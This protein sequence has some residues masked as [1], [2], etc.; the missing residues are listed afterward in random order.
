MLRIKSQK[1]KT[2]PFLE[3]VNIRL[4]SREDAIFNFLRAAVSDMSANPVI[5]IGGGWVRDKILGLESHDI[6]VTVDTMT[7]KDFVNALEDSA[8]KRYGDKF[9][10]L[11]RLLNVNFETSD[12]QVKNIAAGQISINA[13][14]NTGKDDWQPIDVV[15][16]RKEIWTD[17]N[18]G[19]K[20]L[21]NP[22]VI[23]GTVEEDAF[24]RDLTMNCLFYRI[25]DGQIEDFTGGYPD[26]LSMTLR[27][28]AIPE[29][30]KDGKPPGMDDDAWQYHESL[31]IFTEDPVR[32]LRILR[33]YSKYPKSKIY[34][35]D[36]E[37]G[38]PVINAMR[39]PTVQKLL[40]NKLRD[41]KA[42]GI[43]V[44]KNAEEFRKT[45][46]GARPA[47]ALSIMNE[48]GLL[49]NLLNLPGDFSPLNMDQR[50]KWHE[51]TVINH[52]LAVV[53][54]ANDISQVFGLSPE[55]RRMMNM[56]ALFHD[57][58]KLDPRAQKQKP[59]GYLGF[60]GNPN[61]PE[62]M[63]HEESSQK[64][65][66][67]FV[68]MLKLTNL[69]YQTVG[70]IIY[71]HMEPHDHVDDKVQRSVLGKFKD[72]NP[73]WRMIYIHAMS[74]SASKSSTPDYS[75]IPPYEEVL[76]TIEGIKLPP[77]FSGDDII[78]MTG[79]KPGPII[80]QLI[81]AIRE[82][83]YKNLDLPQPL[84]PEE[85]RNQAV[86]IIFNFKNKGQAII[87]E[88]MDRD[89]VQNFVKE[90]AGIL[91][92]KPPTG[93]PGFTQ[94]IRDRIRQERIKNPQMGRQ[95]AEQIVQNMIDSG[96]LDP[97]RV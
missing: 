48:T 83:Q 49:H 84:S 87:P 45:M 67:N 37:N 34:G 2:S 58:G 60:Y 75:K 90:K 15:S 38:G 42:R 86:N 25:N 76:N 44:E 8:K 71:H 91:P 96:E 46:E 85:E 52:T 9:S 12:E 6:D 10:Q 35:M 13:G 4:T 14:F 95:E 33:F 36:K 24:R 68:K 72:E 50:N 43:V 3:G 26:L 41:P 82:Q 16:L 11:V 17:P 69:E 5:R 40:T 79:L 55:E 70:N 39:D 80:G 47:E 18:T 28:P 51:Q 89:Q 66:M 31:R 57:L 88:M 19:E 54:N 7:G 20:L 65:W 62:K 81:A 30:Y 64:V 32:L 1:L 73:L 23:K 59:D 22:I 74:D 61:H 27:P 93:M 63:R 92:G 53:K 77:K 97:Y 21:R 94:L 56:S 78:K 29:G